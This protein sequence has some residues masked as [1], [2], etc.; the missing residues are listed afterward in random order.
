M[1]NR[2]SAS[3]HSTLY[4]AL[5]RRDADQ[6][7]ECGKTPAT[8]GVQRLTI[9]HVDGD[10][11]D[12]TLANVQ[13]LCRSCNTAKRNRLQAEQAAAW[14]RHCKMESREGPA[15]V[16]GNRGDEAPPGA[17]RRHGRSDGGGRTEGERSS[18]RRRRQEIGDQGASP[19]FRANRRYEGPWLDWLDSQLDQKGCISVEDAIYAG[20]ARVD[21]QPQTTRRYVD[22]WTSFEGHLL[23]VED[24]AGVPIIVRRAG[25]T[26]SGAQ[27]SKDTDSPESDLP[28]ERKSQING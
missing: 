13:L 16:T 11:T 17:H 4:D 7:R 20:A 24:N 25:S 15:A 10:R 9:D 28:D 1:G 3:R 6:C 2:F 26:S 21:C 18:F 22:K 23:K 14:R 19:E 5:V 8:L 12:D 27:V